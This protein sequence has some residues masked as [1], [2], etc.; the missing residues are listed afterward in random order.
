MSGQTT[1]MD[2]SNYVCQDI[3][4]VKKEPV[5]QMDG[6][7]IK[8]EPAADTENTFIKQETCICSSEDEKIKQEINEEET[9]KQEIKED[10]E[11]I[12]QGIKEEL[13]VFKHEHEEPSDKHMEARQSDYHSQIRVLDNDSNIKVACKFL[14]SPTTKIESEERGKY[15]NFECSERDDIYIRKYI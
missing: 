6:F 13:T 4:N 11:T 3:N 1:E 15:V 5:G 10:S 14:D 7:T 12:E 9:I 8:T 2:S